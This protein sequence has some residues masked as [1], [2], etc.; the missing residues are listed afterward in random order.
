MGWPNVWL[1]AMARDQLD[2]LFLLE[3]VA[4]GEWG[5][6]EGAF[7]IASFPGATGY[8][9]AITRS[10]SGFSWGTLTPGSWSRTYGTM[11]VGIM[12]DLDVRAFTARGQ[13]VQ[14]RV[15]YPGL[16]IANFEPVWVGSVRDLVWRGSQ[17]VLECVE[18]PAALTGRFSSDGDDVGLF[19]SLSQT[20][21]AD[22]FD[23]AIDTEIEL[24]STAGFLKSDEPG[25]AYCLLITP[26]TGDPYYLLA[27]TKAGNFFQDLHLPGPTLGTEIV[28]AEAGDLVEE[29]AYSQGHPIRMVRRLLESSG[30]T[31]Q[32]GL[33]DY[34][35]R[36]WGFNLEEMWLDVEDM[37]HFLLKTNPSPGEWTLLEVQEQSDALG[38]LSEWLRPGGFFLAMRMGKLTC[39]AV[40]NLFTGSVTPGDIHITDDDII[41]GTITYHTWDPQSPIEYERSRA[42]GRL[43]GGLGV[44]TTEASI[45]SRPARG[46]Y[47]R[48]LQADF[49]GTADWP[50]EV[51]ERLG[52]YDM[53]VPERL[54]FQTAGLR[55]AEP[56]LGD[57]VRV[58][59]DHVP[60]PRG[61]D[62]DNAE[63]RWLVVGGGPDWFA[64][65]CEFELIS[66]P[67]LKSES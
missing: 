6:F 63:R 24:T 54:R 2:L 26:T 49:Q 34:F 48:D 20:T 65:Y 13:A 22:A 66:V 35:P 4:I 56:I 53:R 17:W 58:S 25:D 23:P 10:G 16:D 11:S 21:L 47:E 36:S 18:L 27:D 38:W 31:G 15:G 33:D 59:S 32:N 39:R 61:T 40:L 28:P 43:V 14:L 55:C 8:T 50:T 45:D 30:D 67:N 19:N 12:P 29:V 7:K 37:Q 62:E 3:S 41:P 57:I 46:E 44:T 42:D 1:E 5:A 60:M 9:Y 52:I 51:V 64:G